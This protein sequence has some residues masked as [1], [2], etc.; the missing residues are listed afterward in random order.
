M[1]SFD[2]TQDPSTVY[3][4]QVSKK[5]VEGWVEG[6]S[7]DLGLGLTRCARSL[8]PHGWCWRGFAS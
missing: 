4:E 5:R 7:H 3:P 6:K 1:W 2:S 8:H